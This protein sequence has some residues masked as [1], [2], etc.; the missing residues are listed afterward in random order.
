MDIIVKDSESG[1]QYKIAGNKLDFEIF[2][3]TEKSKHEWV[4][5]RRYYGTL[6]GAV[7]GVLTLILA[8]PGEEAEVVEAEKARIKLG[9]ILND[10]INKISFELMK[11]E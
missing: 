1:K 5:A 9:K 4:S 10:R 8:E 7:Y 11:G 2:Y 3:Q 6:P